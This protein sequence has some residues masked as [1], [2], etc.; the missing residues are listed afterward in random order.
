MGFSKILSALLGEHLKASLYIGLYR[1]YSFFETT[2]YSQ[3][4]ARSMSLPA[5]LLGVLKYQITFSN[6]KATCVC[7]CGLLSTALS[8]I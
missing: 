1:C 5:M 8:P 7:G 6:L 4:K 3:S 2:R